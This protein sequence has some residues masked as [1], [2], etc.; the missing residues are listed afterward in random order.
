[1]K[2]IELNNVMNLTNPEAHTEITAGWFKGGRIMSHFYNAK[3]VAK[4][5]L[6]NSKPNMKV[7]SPYACTYSDI[8]ETTL[9]GNKAYTF[10]CT[11]RALTPDAE[12]VDMIRETIVVKVNNIFYVFRSACS[13]E[14]KAQD[15]PSFQE[16]YDSVQFAMAA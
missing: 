7:E 11:Y 8:S 14:T 16:I 5:L 4:T 10:S 6:K 13:R 9:D 15:V 12:M 1:M 3:D 2:N